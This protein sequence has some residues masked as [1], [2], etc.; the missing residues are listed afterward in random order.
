[1][2]DRDNKIIFV[3][4]PKTGGESVTKMLWNTKLSL[5][6]GKHLTIK[7]YRDMTN[8]EGYYIFSVVRNPYNRALSHYRFLKQFYNP[9]RVSCD[10]DSWIVNQHGAVDYLF[11]PQSYYIDDSVDI[12]KFED[13]N[14]TIKKIYANTGF[15]KVTEVHKNKTK[16]NTSFEFSTLAIEKINQIYEE[17][18]RR[19][20]YVKKT[21]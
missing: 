19:F 7:Q 17:D 6:T 2:I 13:W 20:G 18:F 1:M 3:H 14:N 5:A 8:T 10:F 16:K 15:K 9:P 21:P 12:F 4:I 11:Y